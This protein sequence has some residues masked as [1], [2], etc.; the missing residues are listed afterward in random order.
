LV[1]ISTTKTALFASVCDSHAA[2]HVIREIAGTVAMMSEDEF[3]GLMETVHSLKSP[4]NADRLLRSMAEL[5]RASAKER[6]LI[7]PGSI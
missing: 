7:E 5:D 4:A 1:G 6:E 3:E 2:L